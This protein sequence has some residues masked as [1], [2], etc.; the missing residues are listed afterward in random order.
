M[1]R[2]RLAV[3]RKTW[4]SEEEKISSPRRLRTL[5][6]LTKRF[7]SK[8][9]QNLYFL[10]TWL[11]RHW[12]SIFQI[13]RRSRRVHSIKGRLRYKR[14]YH[15]F[16]Q[17]RSCSIQASKVHQVH[18]GVSKDRNWQNSKIPASGSSH[19]RFPWAEGGARRHAIMK[20]RS[21]LQLKLNSC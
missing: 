8:K 11:L 13:G 5:L 4:S 16:L 10:G 14:R 12:R 15:C 17:R 1:A 21:W 2:Y 3:D 6:P 19:G 20:T 18:R 9:K 7:E